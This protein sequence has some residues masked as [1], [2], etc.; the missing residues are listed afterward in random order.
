MSS[1]LLIFRGLADDAQSGLAE[2]LARLSR[3]V[4]LDDMRRKRLISGW[5]GIGRERHIANRAALCSL[6]VDQVGWELGSCHADS[7]LHCFL[8]RL[9]AL[10]WH[11]LLRDKVALR[12]HPSAIWQTSLFH[13][14]VYA[15]RDG[16]QDLWKSNGTTTA[17]PVVLRSFRNMMDDPIYLW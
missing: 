16:I 8:L 2:I 13:A 14:Q 6:I 5:L 17:R 4:R 15:V 12:S 7:F 1:G 11:E 3:P 10:T 9:V